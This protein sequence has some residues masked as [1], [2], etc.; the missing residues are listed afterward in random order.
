VILRDAAALILKICVE[1]LQKFIRGRAQHQKCS[2]TL[3]PNQSQAMRISHFEQHILP[4]V[5]KTVDV[6]AKTHKN[7]F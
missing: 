2:A 3:V 1:I 5:S 4:K 6:L 7:V